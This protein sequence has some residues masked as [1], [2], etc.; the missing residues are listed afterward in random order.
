ME[1]TVVTFGAALS[2]FAAL[3]A[4]ATLTALPSESVL[5]SVVAAT[6]TATIACTIATAIATAAA[7]TTT[8]AALIAIAAVRVA[9]G[10]LSAPLR[11]G[12]CSHSTTSRADIRA[13]CQRLVA[14]QAKLPLSEQS[15]A[16]V[17]P[18]V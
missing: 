14:E 7:L 15:R 9:A 5:A 4:L 18:C 16:R 17:I 2:A 12:G 10:A 8:A 1:L 13:G 6:I 3:T 11:T